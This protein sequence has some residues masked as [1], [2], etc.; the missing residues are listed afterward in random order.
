MGESE[1]SREL[2]ADRA[3]LL[4]MPA[5]SAMR[6]QFPS[7]PCFGAPLPTALAPMSLDNKGANGED[8]SQQRPRGSSPNSWQYQVFV[9]LRLDFAVVCVCLCVCVR[10]LVLNSSARGAPQ[11]LQPTLARHHCCCKGRWA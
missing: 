5:L 1:A 8:A 3:Q 2:T 9:L 4:H 11:A 6:A 10:A 7:V